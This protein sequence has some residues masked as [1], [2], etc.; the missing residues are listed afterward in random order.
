MQ[1]LS[2]TDLREERHLLVASL[3]N[4]GRSGGAPGQTYRSE[5][6]MGPFQTTNAK[7]FSCHMYFVVIDQFHQTLL[8]G[9]VNVCC[10]LIKVRNNDLT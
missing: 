3:A 2:H 7:S 10:G 4:R 8:V 6:Y 1:G 5:P 9:A